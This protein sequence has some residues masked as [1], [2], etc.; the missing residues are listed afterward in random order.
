MRL[1]RSLLLALVLI[2]AAA[3]VGA[4]AYRM[5]PAGAEIAVHFNAQGQANGLAPKWLGL[6]LMPVIG[7]VVVA[8]LA[9]APR[10]GRSGEALGR[11]G[12]AYGV[13]L[14]GVA[15]M[16][17]VGEAAIAMHA[18]D[19][20]FDVLRWL[21]LAVGVLIVVIGAVLGRIPP[22]GLVGIRTPWTL[23][24]E[25]VWN[26]THR[27]TGRLMTLAGVALAAVA[28]LGA[29]HVDLF[30]ALIV[31]VVAPGVGGAVYSR[32]I[33]GKTTGGDSAPPKP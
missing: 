14:I 25:S 5:L 1:Q 4:W 27:F 10:W 3:A 13:V 19:P 17:L 16:F 9:L 22:N 15:A 28:T 11:P 18:L 29:D 7:L 31:C 6:A 26:R 2:A 33:A 20:A 32:A 8:L 21:F 12:S 23:A 30:V 24:D